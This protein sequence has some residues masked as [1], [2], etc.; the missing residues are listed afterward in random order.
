MKTIPFKQFCGKDYTAF[1]SKPDGQKLINLYREAVQSGDG[2]NEYCLIKTPGCRRVLR[3]SG[4]NGRFRGSIELNEHLFV[5]VDN[6]VYDLLPDFTL[7]PAV[8]PQPIADDGLPVSMAIDN[9][10]LAIVSAGIL[11]AIIGGVVSTPA[12]LAA[13]LFIVTLRGY[14]I[15]VGPPTPDQLI[16]FSINLTTWLPLDFQTPEG[17]P[18]NILAG[19]V[20]HE[21]FWAVG[22]RVTQVFTI[23]G[24]AD[25]PLMPRQDAVIMNGIQA[26]ASLCQ[27]DD[28]LFWLAQNRSGH[29][30]V[31]RATGYQPDKV[32]TY[33]T[34]NALRSLSRIDDAI[35]LPF[36]LNGHEHVW[37]TFPTADRTL[38]FDATENAW[39]EVASWNVT[40]GQYERH[41]ANTMAAAFGK[42]LLGDHTTGW[43]YELSPDI[44]DD[45]DVPIRYMRETPHITQLNKRVSIS[46]CEVFAET[47]MGL[48][49]PRWLNDYSIDE[50]TFDAAVLARQF[51]GQ[52]TAAQA[53]VLTA[54][55]DVEN[56]DP[57]VVLPGDDI[58][59]GLGFV[60]WGVDPQLTMQIS[61]DGGKTWSDEFSRSLGKI[62]EYDLQIQWNRLG[63]GRDPVLRFFG[64]SPTK[65]CF[66][67]AALDVEVFG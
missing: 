12:T 53:A 13:P 17:A 38:G 35:A 4:G 28:T 39:Y 56:Y 54:I 15:M 18:N 52:I 32:T 37:F 20:D 45:A 27:L 42:I 1:S 58:M 3:P 24:D 26:R 44:Y 41:R 61:W 46:R 19:I 40:A 62:G 21:E 63:A 60:A 34:S 51:L 33:A 64:D 49:P 30:T 6:Y 55:Y 7:N 48:S 9:V 23:S 10:S 65:I 25:T 16:Y 29:A 50:V 43:L 22:N 36:Q 11:H 31:V 59:T 67:G 8:T 2:E 5:V 66:T 57:T 47:G 14:W